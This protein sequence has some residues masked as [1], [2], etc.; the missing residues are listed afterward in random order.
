MWLWDWKYIAG[1]FDGEGCVGLYMY[2][3][4]NPISVT[5]LSSHTTDILY[6]LKEWLKNEGI[7][8]NCS[9]PQLQIYGWESIYKFAIKIFPYARIKH[10]ELKFILIAYH[11][12]KLTV[13]GRRRYSRELLKLVIKLHEC[14]AKR[15][16]RPSK[17]YLK[18]KQLLKLI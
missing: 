14:K 16:G 2:S 12:Y 15:K 6:D 3:E 10:K 18:A 9:P 4:M 17:S 11:I 5:Q 1:L 8:S 7:V 13:E